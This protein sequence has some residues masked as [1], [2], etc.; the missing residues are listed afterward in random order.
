MR[1]HAVL[2]LALA[3]TAVSFSSASGVFGQTSAKSTQQAAWE[4]G[5]TLSLAAVGHGEDIAPVT[6]NNLFVEA[7]ANAAKL[8]MTLPDLP[9]KTSDNIKNKASVLGYML[10]TA[11]KAIGETLSAKYDKE[12]ATLFELALKSNVLLMM[13]GPGESTTQAI[14][15]V[16]KTRSERLN[17]PPKITANLLSLIEAGADYSKVKSAVFQMHSDV[18]NYLR[19]K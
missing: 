12:H 18:A 8:N 17:L 3:V 11:G 2:L 14:A 6:V 4:L 1:K 5:D 13:Y 15:N 9:A 19:T 16:I 10:K 7:K